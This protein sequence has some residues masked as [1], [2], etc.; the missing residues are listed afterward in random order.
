MDHYTKLF[1]KMGEDGLLTQELV[2]HL[3]RVIQWVIVDHQDVPL[4]VAQNLLLQAPMHRARIGY[5]AEF[6]R[7]RWKTEEAWVSD[8]V[9]DTRRRI[10][11]KRYGDPDA[12]SGE[13][14][15]V[16]NASKKD[17]PKGQLSDKLAESIA[18]KDPRYTERCEAA[19]RYEHYFHQVDELREAV[20]MYSR[21]TEQWSNNFRQSQRG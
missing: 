18:R 4:E 10:H 12:A 17:F 1:Q 9:A 11:E 8:F 21:N 19:K 13:I 16:L 6:L 5:I 3:W 15:P 14:M 20:N 7:D 2:N